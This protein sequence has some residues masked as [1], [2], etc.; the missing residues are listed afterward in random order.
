MSKSKFGEYFPAL[1]RPWHH[2]PGNARNCKEHTW[3]VWKTLLT[4]AINARLWALQWS[5]SQ[6][7]KMDVSPPKRVT[8]VEGQRRSE[9]WNKPPWNQN[10]IRNHWLQDFRPLSICHFFFLCYPRLPFGESSSSS[11]DTD[12]SPTHSDSDD[13][14][15]FDVLL[16][17][18][19]PDPV[20]WGFKKEENI[21]NYGKLLSYIS[22]MLRNR[23]R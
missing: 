17:L 23:S 10:L 1:N 6:M 14:V 22:R 2:G 21:K 7:V 4:E 15:F 16:H 18:T 19:H 13:T 3:W 11:K 12:V 9:K 20:P 8:V 5:Q